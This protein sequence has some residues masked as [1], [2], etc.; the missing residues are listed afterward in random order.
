MAA[1]AFDGDGVALMN[2]RWA[3]SRQR[4]R[5]TPVVVGGNSGRHPLTMAMDE[6]GHFSTSFFGDW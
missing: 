5:L 2:Y 6:G 1:A 4:G 3:M